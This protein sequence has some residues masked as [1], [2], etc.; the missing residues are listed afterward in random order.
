[1]SSIQTLIDAY[2]KRNGNQEISGPV[3]NGVLTAIADALATPFIGDDGYWYV[4]DP[5]AGEFIR[6]DTLAQGET[7]P[8]GPA[9]PQG[10]TG[11]AGAT[12]STGPA[13]PQGP[14][15]AQGPQGDP[16]TPGITA[17]QVSVDPSTGVPTAI[18]SIVGTTLELAFSG[19]KGEAGAAGEAGPA[20][21][22]GPQ[23]PQGNPGSSVDYPFTLANNLTT[24]DPTVALTAAQGVV[25]Q[26]EVDQLEAL[27]N[28]V[29][30]HHKETTVK[31]AALAVASGGQNLF[32][33]DINLRPGRNYT[34]TIVSDTSNTGYFRIGAYDI[35]NTQTPMHTGTISQNINGNPY[36]LLYTPTD[37][38]L[39]LYVYIRGIAV[40]GTLTLTFIEEWDEVLKPT[41]DEVLFINPGKNLLDPSKMVSPRFLNVDNGIVY[42]T[43]QS[44]GGKYITDYIPIKNGQTLV[45]N[46]S[47]GSNTNNRAALF[48]EKGDLAAIPGTDVLVN[49]DVVRTITN[50]LGY[51]AYAVF[52]LSATPENVQVEQ[53]TAVTAYEPYS[54][55][56]GY[57]P[58]SDIDMSS[59]GEI[60]I[61]YPEEVE[62]VILPI[63]NNHKD[64]TKLH[65]VHCSDNHGSNFGY[66]DAF[67]DPSPASF[68][69]NT[70]DLVAD[71]FS[72]SFDTAKG[73]ILGMTKPGFI[74]LGNHDV[75]QATSLQARFQKYFQPLNDHNG[76]T[77]NTKTY[78]SVDYAT[79]KV[80]CIFLD[81]ND[82]YDDTTGLNMSYFVA[83]K[84]SSEQ[85]NWF[86]SELQAAK[87]SGYDVAVFIHASPDYVDT[88]RMIDPFY[89]GQI[90]KAT[91]VAFV[92]DMVDGF[93]NGGTVSFTDNGVDYSF[94][95]AAGGKFAGWFCG[96]AHHDCYGW[97]KDHPKQFS[98]TVCR[99]YRNT[100]I[101]DG[102]YR[103]PD[104]GVTW[105]YVTINATTH[106]LSVLRMGNQDTIFGT[107]RDAFYV[108][109]DG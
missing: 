92:C 15:G 64:A 99:P 42:V 47:T 36:T 52:L 16:G 37:N 56:A 77:G 79:E 26:G 81:M 102:T 9:G 68:L 73:L 109:Y 80:K 48:K 54:A 11:P 94:T 23:G 63:A 61:N 96:H 10:P 22:A 5:E 29:A 89:D 69:V 101:N 27:V 13:G 93:I 51:D 97:L 100:D 32:F 20:G 34:I 82:G 19:L 50:N 2:I 17:V 72:D 76:L 91:G 57:L 108:R 98:C 8:A 55:I 53:G 21:P 18:A 70:G 41:S 58:S 38:L 75:Y 43:T 62:K 88:E 49:T 46:Q 28:N 66:A 65:F 74:V 95:F 67:T 40:T 85:I 39:R 45:C 14:T 31:T 71:K 86:A 90:A 3:L 105:N 106:T 60:G 107:K 30:V 83:G 104:L 103:I 59:Y 44:A 24:D 7:G 1:M 33:G 87:T 4:Y 6:T 78:Y 12:G 84:M 25:L 35:T